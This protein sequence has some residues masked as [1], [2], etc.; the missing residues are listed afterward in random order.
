MC[1]EVNL[2]PHCMS[3]TNRWVV[4]EKRERSKGKVGRHEQEGKVD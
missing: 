3:G 4:F 1:L 2:N